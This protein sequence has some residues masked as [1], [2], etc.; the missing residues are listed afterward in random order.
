M[1]VEE[2]D[3]DTNKPTGEINDLVE[4]QSVWV[5]SGEAVGLGIRIDTTGVDEPFGDTVEIPL[6][7]EEYEL[8]NGFG[9]QSTGSAY[10]HG[11]DPA[12][13]E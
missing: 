2:I 13:P 5:P 1:I 10:V 6:R 11:A 8:E 4:D 3:P 7:A 12:R 9:S